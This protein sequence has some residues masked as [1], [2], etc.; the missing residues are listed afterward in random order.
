[1]S[2]VATDSSAMAQIS[3]VRAELQAISGKLDDEARTVDLEPPAADGSPIV[4][5]PEGGAVERVA[6]SENPSEGGAS[7]EPPYLPNTTREHAASV[8]VN[9]MPLSRL[10]T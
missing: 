1:M 6:P 8:D 4:T 9:G 7:W 10:S 5:A 3:R 2:P